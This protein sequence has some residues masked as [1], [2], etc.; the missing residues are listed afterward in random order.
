MFEIKKFTPEYENE[1]MDLIK[2]EGDD[3]KVYWEEPNAARYR[4]SFEQSITFI[5]LSDGIICGYSRSIKDALYIY[6]CD[7]L[8]NKEYRGNG[9][10]R[11]LMQCLTVEYPDYPV[12]VMSGNDEYYRKIGAKKEG[13]IFLL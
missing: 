3:W 11:K 7:L 10:G 9:L 12:Y 2:R 5:A 6:V 8:V 4:K 13:S 1:L